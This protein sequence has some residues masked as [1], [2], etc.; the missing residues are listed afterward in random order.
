MGRT[1][2]GR[3]GRGGPGLRHHGEVPATDPL[4]GIDDVDWASLGATYGTAEAVPG[5]LRGLLGDDADR[6][7]AALDELWSTL[8]HQGTI[9]P[10]APAVVPFLVAVAADHR[11]SD[12]VR[13]EVALLL[14]NLTA[15]S[16]FA[17]TPQQWFVVA[18]ARDGDDPQPEVELDQ[19][20]RERLAA[21]VD[22]L[23][24]VLAAGPPRARVATIAVAATVAASLSADARGALAALADDP[25]PRV[26]TAAGVT[27]DLADGAPLTA[28]DL[29]A[30]AAVD[31]DAVDLLEH[32][33]TWPPAVQAVDLVVELCERAVA[34]R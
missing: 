32:I 8:L 13:A 21:L 10:S 28:A 34:T 26:A 31:A 22:R 12:G 5:L 1:P 3:P 9:Y 6:R 25:D 17:T 24:P 14:A 30:R 4:A 7:V 29:L 11:V 23:D 2:P 33:P 19:V 18:F 20:C 16:S 27:L 15:A